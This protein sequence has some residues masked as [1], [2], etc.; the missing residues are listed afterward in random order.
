M[1]RLFIFALFISSFFLPHSVLAHSGGGPP[2]LKI[3]DKFA[4]TNPYYQSTTLLNISQD[5]PPESYLVNKPITV[6]I[7][8][9]QLNK[10]TTIPTDLIDSMVFRWSLL[11]G[12]NFDKQVGSYTEGTDQTY[13]LKEP[14]SYLLKLEAKTSEDEDYV[15]LDT[16][17]LN[18]LPTASYSLPKA[19]VFI[20]VQDN[21]TQKPLLFV[22][23]ST[24]DKHSTIKTYLWSMGNKIQKGKFIEQTFPS[25][26]AY[27]TRMMYHRVIDSKG[28][29]SDIGF[30]GEI[31]KGHMTFV[32]F[33]PMKSVAITQGS[34]AEAEKLAG[35][36]AK[37]MSGL[38][39][40]GFWFIGQIIIL[41]FTAILLTKLFQGKK[42]VK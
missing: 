37:S 23:Q 29:N 10:Q 24:A 27:D 38:W 20:G 6:A 1:K 2:F 31:A 16:V 8:M 17:Q 28:F 12:D 35:N 18:V 13:T 14:R 15:V 19:R 34:Y 22:S 40:I 30:A 3:N 9:D 33:T 5:I 4:A 41:S 11:E 39:G 26:S 25:L 42:K 36:Q 21:D 32:P 7:D